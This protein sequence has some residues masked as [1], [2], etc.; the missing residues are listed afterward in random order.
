MRPSP[1]M[2]LLCA[3]TAIRSRIADCRLLKRSEWLCQRATHRRVSHG[4]PITY[5]VHCSAVRRE[6]V[7]TAQHR[8]DVT[9][10]GLSLH[11]AL[12]QQE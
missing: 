5:V 4:K 6:Y 11:G 2:F 10:L 3:K 1:Q 9:S 7:Q 12:V 8:N